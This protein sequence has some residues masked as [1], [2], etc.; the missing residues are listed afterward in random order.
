MIPTTYYMERTAAMPTAAPMGV[1]G[2]GGGAGTCAIP[3][4]KHRAAFG[5]LS[6]ISAAGNS[7]KPWAFWMGR[8]VGLTTDRSARHLGRPST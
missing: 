1:V 3:S 5:P 4:A 7:V 8:Q 6:G 2:F